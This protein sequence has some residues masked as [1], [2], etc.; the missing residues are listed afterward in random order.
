MKVYR[1]HNCAAHHR[2]E[3]TLLKCAIPRVAWVSGH[4]AFALIAWCR[5]ITITLHPQLE[6]ALKS[7]TMIDSTGCGGACTKRHDIIQVELTADL[8]PRTSTPSPG[9]AGTE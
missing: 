7:K 4:G 9:T 3:R 6:G 5:D 8:V 2:T 1:R